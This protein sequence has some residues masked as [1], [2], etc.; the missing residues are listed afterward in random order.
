[1]FPLSFEV[2]HPVESFCFDTITPLYTIQLLTGFHS[3]GEG[4]TP[5]KR[6][7]I[8]PKANRKIGITIGTCITVEFGLPPTP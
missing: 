4:G 3:Q 8:G 6:E 2:N 5:L 1:M 7:K